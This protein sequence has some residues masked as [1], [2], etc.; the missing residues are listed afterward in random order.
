MCAAELTD[1]EDNW[2]QQVTQI[3]A[4][5]KVTQNVWECTTVSTAFTSADRP[6]PQLN[7]ESNPCYLLCNVAPGRNARGCH[8]FYAD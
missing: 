2:L 6:W 7:A 1:D 4:F 5:M 8:V 3:N